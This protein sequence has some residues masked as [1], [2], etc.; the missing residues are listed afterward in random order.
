MACV[1]PGDSKLAEAQGEKDD[2]HRLAQAAPARSHAGSCHVRQA[3]VE[4]LLEGDTPIHLWHFA[5][6]GNFENEAPGKS[7]LILEGRHPFT[8]D[9][10]VGRAQTRLKSDQPFVFLNACRV[11][12]SGLA[13]TGMGGWAKVLIQDCGVGGFL[14]PVW[15]VDDVQARRFAAAFY[16]FVRR[17]PD[18]TVAQAVREARSVL[19]ELP[20]HDPTWLAYSLYLPRTRMR[21]SSCSGLS[22]F[23]Q[24]GPISEDWTFLCIILLASKGLIF[25]DWTF[26]AS[27]LRVPPVRGVNLPA[28]PISRCQFLGGKRRRFQTKSPTRLRSQ[29]PTPRLLDQSSHPDPTDRQRSRRARP[30]RPARPASSAS[31]ARA[32]T[33]TGPRHVAD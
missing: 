12:Q 1:A 27:K 14:A 9:D 16:D 10:I 20:E 32:T 8:P 7:P 15:E 2:L 21:K 6:H 28:Q 19:R 23:N 29:P 5:C 22:S 11:G 25:R 13:L 26:L 17:R 31:S 30:G 33:S 4:R 18:C 3:V 24:K